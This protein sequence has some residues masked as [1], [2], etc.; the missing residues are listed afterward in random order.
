MRAASKIDDV[1]DAGKAINRVDNIADAGGVASK[2]KGFDS[3]K[4]LKRYIGPAGV[5]NEWHHIVEQ[6]QISKSG[7]CVQ[8][9]QNTNNIISIDKNTHRAI[10]GYYSSIQPFTQG[11][12]VRNWLVGQSFDMQYQFGVDVIKL[13]M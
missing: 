8:A 3:Y 9:I 11:K 5:G 10:S 1:I 4:Q 13:F 12:T 2:G 6:N 7:F